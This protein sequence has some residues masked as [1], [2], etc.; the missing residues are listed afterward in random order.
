MSEQ[1]SFSERNSTEAER[2]STKIKLL[3]FFDRELLKET[4][5]PFSAVITDIRN[6]GM[7]IELTDSMAFGMV[8]LSTLTDD[9]YF[10]R[11]GGAC[12]VGRRSGR[13]FCIGQTVHVVIQKVDRFKRQMDFQLQE[14]SA[15]V[16]HRG[17]KAGT[18]SAKAPTKQRPRK[19]NR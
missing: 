15:Q 16:N 2:D 12:L 1:I 3:E 4:K 11:D 14:F 5:T 7:F 9:L 17:K 8:H 19:R 6:H 13:K 18:T 10:V